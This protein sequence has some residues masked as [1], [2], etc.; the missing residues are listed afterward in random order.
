M[1]FLVVGIGREL[2]WS[3]RISNVKDEYIDRVYRSITERDET[4]YC[5]DT[6][7]P[8]RATFDPHL[9]ENVTPTKGLDELNERECIPE[10]NVDW[11]MD[12]VIPV[13]LNAHFCRF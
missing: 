3:E 11:S 4:F 13:G 8:I 1:K 5:C 7:Y 10:W 12:D 9:Y 2:S 6:F